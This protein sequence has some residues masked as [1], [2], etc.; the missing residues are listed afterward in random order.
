MKK[1]TLTLA[2][3]LFMA[4]QTVFATKHTIIT[5]GFTYSPATTNAA[6]GDT[7][8]ISAS[9]SHPLV[10]V[11]QADWN[12]NT[13]TPISGWVNK[14][15]TYSFVITVVADIYFGCANHMSTAQMKGKITV[16]SVGINQVSAAAYKVALFPNPVTNG[17]F[18][19]KTEG[20]TTGSASKILIYDTEGKLLETYNLTAVETPVK[21]RLS[22]GVYFYDVMVNSKQVHRGKFLVSLTK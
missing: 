22:S 8:S 7:V 9:V 19:V 15:A 2:I 4:V 11:S 12:T 16:T 17:E 3:L 1:S 10:M 5:S 21:T 20:Y 18:T 6:V 13:A 14:T